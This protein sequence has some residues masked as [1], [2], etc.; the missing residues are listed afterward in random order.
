M[1]EVQIQALSWIKDMKIQTLLQAAALVRAQSVVEYN[2]DMQHNCK[3][4][5]YK[6][7]HNG[8]PQKRSMLWF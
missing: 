7:A 8:I 4:I 2:Y 6:Y 3:T 5:K 1:Y